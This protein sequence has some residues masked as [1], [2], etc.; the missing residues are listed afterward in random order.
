MKCVG[1]N[2]SELKIQSLMRK[3]HKRRARL[4]VHKIQNRKI[5]TEIE[6]NH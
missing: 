1:D 4:R 5:A 3:K 2:T 6:T